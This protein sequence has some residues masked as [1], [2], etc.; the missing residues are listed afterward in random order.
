MKVINSKEI[1]EIINKYKLDELS[2]SNFKNL[3]E[4]RNE[5]IKMYKIK[6]D[7]LQVYSMYLRYTKQINDQ[8]NNFIQNYNKYV[9]E[10]E[11]EMGPVAFFKKN[12]EERL[13]EDRLRKENNVNK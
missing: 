9:K 7:D 8:L 13:K 6:K 4:M 11:N 2:G 12:L 3:V 1:N 5:I 10:N